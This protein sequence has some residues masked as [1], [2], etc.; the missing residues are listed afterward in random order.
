MGAT[1]S[2]GYALS[3]ENHAR[4][5]RHTILAARNKRR[6]DVHLVL[7]ALLLRMTINPKSLLLLR[8]MIIVVL[9]H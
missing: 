3:R 8:A 1:S 5:A 7:F 9:Y 6:Q 4:H 2:I